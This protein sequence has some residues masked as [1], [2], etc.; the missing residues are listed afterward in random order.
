MKLQSLLNWRCYEV[1]KRALFAIPDCIYPI[2]NPFRVLDDVGP[3]GLEDDSDIGLWVKMK[4]TAKV[5]DVI[6]AL[7]A[8]DSSRIIVVMVEEPLVLS[9]KDQLLCR[10]KRIWFGL[11]ISAD[12]IRNLVTGREYRVDYLEWPGAADDAA[13]YGRW[14]LKDVTPSDDPPLIRLI[15]LIVADCR[16]LGVSEQQIDSFL[17]DELNMNTNGNGR[18]QYYLLSY[19]ENTGEYAIDYYERGKPVLAIAD[20]DEKEFRFKFVRVFIYHCNFI[21]RNM[22]NQKNAEALFRDT[23]SK[24][25]LTAAY[26]KAV[27]EYCKAFPE[28]EEQFIHDGKD[29]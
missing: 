26:Q 10:Q 20:C 21:S 2:E 11:L 16:E 28:K 17:H 19:N 18:G 22:N 5:P 8:L 9:A 29:C 15:D 25:G 12:S 27:W 7:S 23:A 3:D 13:T 14:W 6:E 1:R 4:E 24:F